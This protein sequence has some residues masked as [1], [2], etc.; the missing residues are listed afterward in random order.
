MPAIPEYEIDAMTYAARQ[1][2]LST[3]MLD[4]EPGHETITIDDVV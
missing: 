4:V 1:R 3:F 2:D